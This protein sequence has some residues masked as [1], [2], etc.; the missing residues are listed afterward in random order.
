MFSATCVYS[1]FYVA[2]ALNI[3]LFYALNVIPPFLL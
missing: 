2:L 3:G 1:I